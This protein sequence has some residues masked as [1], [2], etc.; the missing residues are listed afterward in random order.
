[1][2][3]WIEGSV[4]D[5]RIYKEKRSDNWNVVDLKFNASIRG[6]DPFPTGLTT[7]E[8]SKMIHELVWLLREMNHDEM[9]DVDKGL[10]DD[11]A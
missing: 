1:M 6:D 4:F 3:A 7:V 5:C 11:A 10:T 8:V 2:T 9:L